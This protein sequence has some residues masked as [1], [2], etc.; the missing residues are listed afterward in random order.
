MTSP[1]PDRLRHLAFTFSIIILQ[2]TAAAV[3]SAAITPAYFSSV[4]RLSTGKWV[5]IKVTETGMHQISDAELTAMGFSDPKKVAICGYPA[6]SLSDYRLTSQTP[7]DVPVV[8][9]IRH[10]GKLI[11]YGEGA[12]RLR[13]GQNHS[14]GTYPTEVIRNNYAGY[15]AYFLTDAL[16]PT[17]PAEIPVGDTKLTP[18]TTG[19]GAIHFEEETDHTHLLG[20]S[21]FG[22]SFID[23][24]R[25]QYSYS[26]PGF[27]SGGDTYITVQ[28]AFQVQQSSALAITAPSGTTTNMSIQATTSEH[29]VYSGIK[30]TVTDTPDKTAD[31]L[32]T[33]TLDGTRIN[34]PTYARLDYFTVTYQRNNTFTGPQQTVIYPSFDNTKSLEVSTTCPSMMM[35]DVTDPA[36]PRSFATK[37][38][39]AQG[40]ETA[41][42]RAGSPG[43]CDI[44]KGTEAYV[45]SFDPD[46]ELLHVIPAGD[47]ANQNLHSMATPRMVIIAASGLMDE[48]NRL[49]QA[50]R[51]IDGMDVAVVCQD[52]IYNEFS[53]GTPH[54]TALRRFVKMLYERD[55]AK[56]HSVLLFGRASTDNADRSGGD[57]PE[58]RA[59]HVPVLLQEELSMAGHR[60]RSYCT[61]SYVGMTDD[62]DDDEFNIYTTHMNVAVSRIP[63][64]NT[65]TASTIVNKTIAYMQN[66]P[67][68]RSLGAVLLMC[69]KGDA[70]GH[71]NDATG[72]AEVIGEL[73]PSTNIYKAFNPIFPIR[74]NKAEELNRYASNALTKGVAY[75]SYSGH[76]TP[77]A[78]AAEPLWSV[79]M[80]NSLEYEAPPFAVFATCRALYF[81]HPGGSVAESILFKEHGGAIG[82]VGALREVYKEKNQVINLELGRAFFGATPGT[83]IGDIFRTARRSSVSATDT[84]FHDLIINT[85][86][87]NLIGDPEVKV[88]RPG[89]QAVA[90]SINGHA[91]VGAT[92]E[93]L[94]SVET[95]IEGIVTDSDGNMA[96]D[97]NGEVVLTMFDAE[98]KATVINVGTAPDEDTYLGAEVSM[99]DETIFEAVEKVEKGRFT[100]HCHFPCPLR[101]GANRIT[102]LA[103]STDGRSMAQ[104]LIAGVNVST[105]PANMELTEAT[106]PEI[107]TMY[108]DTPRFA[109]GDITGGTPTLHAEIAPNALGIVGNSSQPGRS[110][111]L[112]LD[113]S[114]NITDVAFVLTPDTDG[115]ASVDLPLTDIA[116]GPHTLT[117]KVNNY[118]GQSAER[119]IRFTAVNVAGEAV[120]TVEEYPASDTATITFD[121]GLSGEI[122]ARLV[123]K[124]GLGHVAFTDD[125]AT[126]PYRWNLRDST[127]NDVADGPYTVEIYYTD[128]HRYGATPATPVVVRR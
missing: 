38:Q 41:T 34:R 54:I 102:L 12:V 42:V 88:H 22:R 90:T 125:K 110:A 85:L 92:I 114:R 28:G 95:V 126:F 100:F 99:T 107:T 78:F 59:F 127:G 19:Y 64:D 75:W 97:F 67:A 37:V 39:P 113:G 121:S 103:T 53:S 43:M 50:H 61:D 62:D 80:T 25:Q 108:L 35:W 91:P 109:D 51:D 106:V 30:R 116:D 13:I 16:A 111:T 40:S 52:R 47:I 29:F 73:S 86:S 46:A 81:D 76:S 104:G 115:G 74:N 94:N 93:V 9:S 58:F 87:Y 72:L 55:P 57:R 15:G 89:L 69:D 77:Q 2:L 49:A 11:F 36:H 98:R 123:I 32:Y 79:D 122:T 124:D 21:F 120:A 63:A 20:N 33:L 71:M 105:A 96:E 60:S 117:L 128:G 68:A 45:V 70:N 3:A 119:T 66:P 8:P 7:D 27:I 83:T 4:S 6:V 31:G 56:L 84:Q 65:G 10:N 23:E 17:A 14:G 101:E 24:R 112:V 118:A 18:V 1:I 82:V 44:S 26:M 5:K 48:A